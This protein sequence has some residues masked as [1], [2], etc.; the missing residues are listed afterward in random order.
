MLAAIE[1][2]APINLNLIS[3]SSTSI[4]FQWEDPEDFG[5][6]EILGFKVYVAEGN[7]D[8]SVI[9]SAESYSDPT[10]TVWE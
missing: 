1:P 8:Y 7:G 3:R 10:V 4:T 5:G 6:I 9:A 2:S